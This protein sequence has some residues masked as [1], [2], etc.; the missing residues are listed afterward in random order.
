VLTILI[1]APVRLL[2]RS[3]DLDCR[4]AGNALDLDAHVTAFREPREAAPDRLDE[5]FEHP[6]VVGQ[7]DWPVRERSIT[8]CEGLTVILIELEHIGSA[9]IHRQHQGIGES[10]AHA[11]GDLLHGDD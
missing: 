2:T 8:I 4:W 3:D 10:G 6:V 11:G 5:E 7:R 1:V 9:G